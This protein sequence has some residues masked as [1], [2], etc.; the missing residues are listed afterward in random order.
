MMLSLTQ[1][2]LGGATSVSCADVFA[3]QGF[4]ALASGAL[5]V[6]HSVF[7]DPSGFPSES[8]V[9][10]PITQLAWNEHR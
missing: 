5:T 6:S 7:R 10:T 2:A 9:S 1:A 3:S 4:S 8:Q